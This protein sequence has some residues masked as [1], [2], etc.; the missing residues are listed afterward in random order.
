M[1]L[2]VSEQGFFR[3]NTLLEVH[4]QALETTC[5][6]PSKAHPHQG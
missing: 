2:S 1:S 6:V 3:L 5:H 4:L